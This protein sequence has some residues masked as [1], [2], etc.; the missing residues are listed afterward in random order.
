MSVHDSLEDW[1]IIFSTP[2]VVV[3]VSLTHSLL[4]PADQAVRGGLFAPFSLFA[5]DEAFLT[6]YSAPRV[7]EM[8]FVSHNGAAF[9]QTLRFFAPA[10]LLSLR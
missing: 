3:H 5:S 6:N 1:D 4:L 9:S 2:A 10:S 7:T 8:F